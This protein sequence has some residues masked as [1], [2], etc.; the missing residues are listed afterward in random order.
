M[1]T[2]NIAI[3]GT[4]LNSLGLVGLTTYQGRKDDSMKKNIEENA[5][6]INTLIQNVNVMSIAL[7][8][9]SFEKKKQEITPEMIHDLSVRISELEDSVNDIKVLL[10]MSGNADPEN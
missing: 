4:A 6:K 5:Q 7:K 3:A 9:L 8:T 1:S 2:D 10:G